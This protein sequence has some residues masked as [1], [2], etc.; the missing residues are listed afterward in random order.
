MQRKQGSRT[1]RHRHAEQR[2]GAY[3]TGGARRSTHR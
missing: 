1:A 3:A 2:D